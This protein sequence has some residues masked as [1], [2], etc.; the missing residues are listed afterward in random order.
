MYGKILRIPLISVLSTNPDFLRFRFLLVDFLVMVKAL[1]RL[2]CPDP[3]SL[4]RL[5]APRFVFIFGITSLL[6]TSYKD[7]TFFHIN[8]CELVIIFH[9]SSCHRL[10]IPMKTRIL[11]RFRKNTTAYIQFFNFSLNN[12]HRFPSTISCLRTNE[13][14]QLSSFHLWFL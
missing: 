7:L 8:R 10:I 2:I 1:E 12:E 14:H 5:A 9:N 13:H 6:Y 4:K 11:L 3:V